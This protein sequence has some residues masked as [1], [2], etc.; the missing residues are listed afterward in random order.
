CMSWDHRA[1]DG[2]Y[3]AQFLSEVRRRIEAW[4]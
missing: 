1:L 3:A 2:A 4:I